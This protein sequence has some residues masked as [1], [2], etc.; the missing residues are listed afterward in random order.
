MEKFAQIL[1]RMPI[2]DASSSESH[3]RGATPF[4]VQVNFDIPIFEVQRDVDVIDKCLN[5]LEGYFQFMIFPIGKILLLCSSK[6][7]P[8]S[9]TS[10]KPTANRGTRENP[11]CFQ[12]NPL[13]TLSEMPSRNNNTPWGAM[14]TNT[15]NGPRCGNKRIKMCTN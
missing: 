8:M 1:W 3:S 13:G 11:H 14:R 15:S 12:Q 2:G 9:R 5:M 6:S 10:E 7:P 4:K